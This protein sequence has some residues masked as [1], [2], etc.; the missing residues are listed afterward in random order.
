M[1]DFPGFFTIEN[2]IRIIDKTISRPFFSQ[3]KEHKKPDRDNIVI[4]YAYINRYQYGFDSVKI[5]ST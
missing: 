3:Q 4:K 1:K 5:T 2:F